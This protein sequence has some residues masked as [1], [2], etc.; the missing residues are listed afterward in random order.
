MSMLVYISEL[1][2][3]HGKMEGHNYTALSLHGFTLLVVFNLLSHVYSCKQQLTIE[4]E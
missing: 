4:C 1:V 2:A 3:T